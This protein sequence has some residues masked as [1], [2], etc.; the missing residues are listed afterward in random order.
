MDG[1]YELPLNENVLGTTVRTTS[2]DDGL[3]TNDFGTV[4]VARANVPNTTDWVNTPVA[5]S[6]YYCHD[7]APALAGV[8]GVMVVAAGQAAV[9]RS[10]RTFS[11]AYLRGFGTLAITG[12][13]TTFTVTG[14]IVRVDPWHDPQYVIPLLEYFD[15][16]GLTSRQD[17]SRVLKDGYESVLAAEDDVGEGSAGPGNVDA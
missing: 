14:A 8:I 10:S 3:D 12:L 6:C 11:G 7:S 2:T 13:L 15:T 4:G 16:V 1:T 17:S 9:R 5:S